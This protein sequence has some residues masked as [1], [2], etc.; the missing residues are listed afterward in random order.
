MSQSLLRSPSTRLARPAAVPGRHGS[1]HTLRTDLVPV[2]VAVAVFW[3]A[4][5]GGTYGLIDRASLAIAVWWALLMAVVLGLWPLVAPPRAAVV[6]GGLLAAFALLN[7]LSMTWAASAE[8]AFTEFNRAALYLG[9]FLVAVCGGT[10]GNV[11]RWLDGLAL[12]IVATGIFALVSRL[13]PTAIDPGDVPE[14]LPA[15][16]ARLSRPV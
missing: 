6:A 12:G 4:F 10:R 3:T 1:G 9:L 7:G 11:G 2:L 15:A 13:F 16:L 14:F 8:R 5:D